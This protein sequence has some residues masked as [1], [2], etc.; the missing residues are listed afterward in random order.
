MEYTLVFTIGLFV[1]AVGSGL[2]CI[3]GLYAGKQVKK[4]KSN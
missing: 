3:I 1:G 2:A 4:H